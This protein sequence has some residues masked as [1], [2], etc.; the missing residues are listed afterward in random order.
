MSY[1]SILNRNFVI[2]IFL[3]LVVIYFFR[4]NLGLTSQLLHDITKT[5]PVLFL[6]LAT[7]F[8]G[9]NR[10]VSLALLLS[11]AGDLAGEEK[12]FLAQIAL[13]ALAHI[14]YIIYFAKRATINSKNRIAIAIWVIVMLI[15]GGWMVSH[16]SSTTIKIACSLYILLIGTMAATTFSIQATHKPLYV[17]A[18][19]LFVFSD[20][21]IAWNKFIEH[22]AGAGVTIM[23]TYFAAQAIFAWLA[24]KRE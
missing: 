8:C 2:V 11:A 17:I 7:Y 12:I 6:S 5:L 21:C 14:A 24:L 16:I 19:L 3:A 23:T 22:F 4:N 10:L 15:F 9:S 18:A 20:S 13:F 1:K